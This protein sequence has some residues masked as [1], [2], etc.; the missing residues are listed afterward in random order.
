MSVPAATLT[1]ERR[2]ARA[3]SVPVALAAGALLLLGRPLA[4]SPP[5]VLLLFAA[6]LT[7][8][9]LP[10][11]D[12]FDPAVFPAVVVAAA[13]IALIGMATMVAGPPV[14]TPATTLVVPLNVVAAVAEEAFFRR[15]LYG[16]LRRWGIPAA[17]G[18]SALLFAAMHVPLYGVA[19]FWVDLGA[20]LL[21]GWQRWVS[22]GWA[23]PAAT[24]TAAN[25]L[26]VLR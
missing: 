23:A 11:I 8:S 22:G 1:A 9:A 14:P 25:V 4:L 18:G 16:D 6:V 5:M 12:G 20:G 24:H 10:S 26:A 21:F 7:I 15:L 19:V 17:I 2:W 3:S 13:G